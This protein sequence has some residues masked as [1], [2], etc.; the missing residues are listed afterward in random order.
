MSKYYKKNNK[1]SFMRYSYGI[2]YP[3]NPLLFTFRKRKRIRKKFVKYEWRNEEL[4]DYLYSN[5]DDIKLKNKKLR[6]RQIT[7]YKY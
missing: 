3:N 7:Q 6:W 1:V 4:S 5:I 2:S